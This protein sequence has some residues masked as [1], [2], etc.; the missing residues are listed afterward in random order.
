MG[1]E[2]ER[3]YLVH[4]H[5]LPVLEKGE[6][7]IQG[8]LAE[9]PSIRFRVTGSVMVITI[10]D[11]LTPSR[12]FE[13]ETPVKEITVEEIEKLKSL[14]LSPPIVKIRYKI[15]DAQGLT[16]EIDVYDGDN[17]GLITVDIELPYENYPLVFPEWV[18]SKKEITGDMRYTNLNLGR[19]PFMTWNPERAD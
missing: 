9:T 14:A 12:R 16:W 2:I 13:L 15:S 10:K 1:L 8:Y 11:Y 5:L 7:M 17:K 3:K 6:R 19:R 4:A 18:D